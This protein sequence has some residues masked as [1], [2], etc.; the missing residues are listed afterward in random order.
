MNTQTRICIQYFSSVIFC[1]EIFCL[2]FYRK[3]ILH[4]V[5]FRNKF[6]LSR[7]P[8]FLIIGSSYCF[9]VMRRQSVQKEFIVFWTLHKKNYYSWAVKKNEHG[10]KP[11]MSANTAVSCKANSHTSVGSTK[12][13]DIYKCTTCYR[14]MRIVAET[15]CVER[16]RRRGLR[17]TA[18][19]VE[20]TF[21]AI[22]RSYPYM[23]EERRLRCFN[24]RNCLSYPRLQRT[25]MYS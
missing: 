14:R 16:A 18:T 8:F 20:S 9:S 7:L 5:F 22:C 21:R 3:Y 13:C 4:S 17:V 25:V 23:S 12:A 24:V 6:C 1:A 11:Q 15:S 19:E 2:F 10:T